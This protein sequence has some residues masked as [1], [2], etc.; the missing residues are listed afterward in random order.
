MFGSFSDWLLRGRSRKRDE[1][2]EHEIRRQ[3][4][5]GAER[6]RRIIQLASQQEREIKAIDVNQFVTNQ[7]IRYYHKLSDKWFDGH[8]VAVHLDDGPDKPYYTISYI[9]RQDERIEKQ[10]TQDRLELLEFDEEKT[11]VILQNV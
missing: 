8:V 11:W 4:Q 10:T 9:T 3:Q 2:A 1:D 6:A 7:R 5:E